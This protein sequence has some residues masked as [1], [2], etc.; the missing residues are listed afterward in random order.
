MPHATFAFGLAFLLL[1]SG[2]VMRF[3][4]PEISGFERPPPWLIVNDPWGLA[5][6][7]GLLGKEIPYLLLMIFVALAQHRDDRSYGAARTLGYAPFWAWLL[8]VFP[9]IYK[10]LRLP[11]FA[12][13]AFSFSVVD[14]SLILGP[15]NPPTLSVWLWR[16]F[17]DADLSQR[18][19]A[20]AGAMVQIGLVFAAIGLWCAGEQLSRLCLWP[21]AKLGIQMGEPVG[22]RLIT[23]VGI[24]TLF[25]AFIFG[26]VGL[27]LWSIARHWRFPDNLPTAF[28]LTQW[29]QQFTVLQA[30][31][32]NTLLLGVAATAIAVICVIGCLE[33]AA[34]RSQNRVG[35]I[36]SFLY[37][38]LLVPQ[39]GFL[40]GIQ[41]WLIYLNLDGS[42]LALIWCH[43]LFVFPYVFLSLSSHYRHL[44]IRQIHTARTLGASPN[45]TFWRIKWPLLKPSVLTAFA[46]GFAVSVGL[47]LPTLAAAVGRISTLTVEAV[48]LAEGRNWRLIG[49][50]GVVQMAPPWTVFWLAH[51]LSCAA[52]RKS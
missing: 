27:A 31:F 18:R 21:I 24:M 43:V 5:L 3:L 41:L 51:R 46:V 29:N 37:W 48:T 38:P 8:V 33:N 16:Q 22:I 1:P 9:L 34:R 26:G 47:Y 2:W 12:V 35:L 30:P 44:D 6:I 32:L 36:E 25:G 45:K 15:S 14:V 19:V 39:I 28:T 20:G 7:L 13:L 50:Y 40:F 17:N 42:W 11:L 23:A 49:L 52:H 10:H 4:S